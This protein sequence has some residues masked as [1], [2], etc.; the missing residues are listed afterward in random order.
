MAIYHLSIKIITRGSGK[1]AVASAAYRSGETLHNEY[2]GVTHDYTR[3]GG[4][5]H[6]E[7]V[8]QENA[9]AEYADR[10]ALWNAV[11]KAERYKMAQLAWEIEI[12]L[13]V[14]L[15]REEQISL[16]RRYAKET[17]V[18]AGMCA[19]I[20]V[21]DKGDGNPHA[22]IM[23]TMRPLESDGTWGAKSSTANGRK[24]NSVD[25]NDRDKAEEWR[26]AW[27]AYADTSN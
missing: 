12:A 15:S 4:V 20:C 7:I 22:H 3:K 25:W 6:I 18:S 17:F 24:I 16:A 14:E 11:E 23:L 19:D 2:D 9:P 10:N 1:S 5:V 8:L 27:A 13:P 21:H 26:K